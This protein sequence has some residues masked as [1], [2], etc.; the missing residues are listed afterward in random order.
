[1]T[2]KKLLVL[3][4]AIAILGLGSVAS[5]QVVTPMPRLAVALE[6]TGL[7]N[8]LVAGQNATLAR[9]TLDTTGSNT[10]VRIASLPLMV[11]TGAGATTSSL[12]N[13]RVY[14]ETTGGALNSGTNVS[15][16]LANGMN[17][18]VLDTAF[19]VQPNTLATLAVRCDIASNLVN[20]GTYQFSLNTAN[21]VAA[22]PTT[23]T[24]ARVSLRGVVGPVIVPPVVVPTVPNT[25]AGGQAPTNIAIIIGSLAVAG[26]GL[27]Y[28]RKAAR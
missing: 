12:T 23:G 15:T 14:N 1:M 18:V 2:F 28:A 26:F 10:A 7:T 16:N 21:V 20:G 9:L 5:A 22:D 11:N 17:N 25:G 13:C 4:V 19:V 3:P 8:S 6:T 24:A 27:A